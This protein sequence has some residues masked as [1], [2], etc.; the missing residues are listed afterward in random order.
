[1]M[2]A[3]RTL[4]EMVNSATYN[5]GIIYYF[6]FNS[7]QKVPCM[8]DCLHEVILLTESLFQL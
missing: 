1:M 5:D 6:K 7:L 4:L 3:F 8:D 2:K